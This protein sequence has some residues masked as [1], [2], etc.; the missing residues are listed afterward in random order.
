ME[1]AIVIVTGATA[2][3]SVWISAIIAIAL[4]GIIGVFLRRKLTS[5]TIISDIVEEA[6]QYEI[7]EY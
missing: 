7:L 1:L 2:G 4:V 6:K 3:I 5:T